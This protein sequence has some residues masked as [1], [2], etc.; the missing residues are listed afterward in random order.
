MSQENIDKFKKYA[1]LI[2]I[3]PDYY[4][5]GEQDYE[6]KSETVLVVYA[7][8]EHTQELEYFVSEDLEED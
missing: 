5:I 7:D 1:K 8:K 6:D 2:G 3:S 4:D